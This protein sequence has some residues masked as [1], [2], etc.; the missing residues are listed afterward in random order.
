M[1]RSGIYNYQVQIEVPGIN[2]EVVI[3]GAMSYKDALNLLLEEADRLG[4]TLGYIWPQTKVA[5]RK[6]RNDYLK[7]AID[8]NTPEKKHYVIKKV[9]LDPSI[10]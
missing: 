4:A 3:L 6:V 9:S 2:K 1:G 10:L 7:V 8:L 5:Q